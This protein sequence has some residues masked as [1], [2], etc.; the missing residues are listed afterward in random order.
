MIKKKNNLLQR[1]DVV[2]LISWKSVALLHEYTTRF[3]SIKPRKYS[4][5]SVRVQKKLKKAISRARELGILAY[6]Q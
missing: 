4:T 1:Q 3:D 6:T 5:H 2:D